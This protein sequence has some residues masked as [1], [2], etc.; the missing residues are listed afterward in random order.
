VGSATIL[1]LKTGRNEVRKLRP[2]PNL[3][4]S[5]AHSHKDAAGAS[6]W[7]LLDTWNSRGFGHTISWKSWASF[8]YGRGSGNQT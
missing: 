3:I 7:V 8:C 6:I 1:I 2:W 4:C 5:T